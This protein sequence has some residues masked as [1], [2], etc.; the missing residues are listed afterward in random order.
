MYMY[1][2]GFLY[3]QQNHVQHA[4]VHCYELSTTGWPTF[5]CTG[6]IDQSHAADCFHYT[7]S[8]QVNHYTL[9]RFIAAGVSSYHYMHTIHC[10]LPYSQ[11]LAWLTQTH[12]FTAF[13]VSCFS[14]WHCWSWWPRTLSSFMK[15]RVRLSETS[16]CWGS[17][18]ASDKYGGWSLG[19]TSS[20]NLGQ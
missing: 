1:I 16:V 5:M 15:G 9:N 13:R 7:H 17:W 8:Y 20:V 4:T 10:A 12:L 14:A 19:R 11:P 3:T 6:T 18:G 2:T